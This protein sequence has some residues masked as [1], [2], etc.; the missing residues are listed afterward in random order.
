M[1]V[2]QQIARLAECDGGWCVDEYQIATGSGRIRPDPPRSEFEHQ[3]GEVAL[4]NLRGAVLSAG[5]VLE[6]APQ[7]ICHSGRSTPGAPRALF[8]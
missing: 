6:L 3:P 4:E 1:E 7:P 5:A 2:D 8:G